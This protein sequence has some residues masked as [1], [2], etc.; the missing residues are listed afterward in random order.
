MQKAVEVPQIQYVGKI[1]EAL[2]VVAHQPV[3]VDA[4]ALSQTQCFE[5]DEDISVGT[6]S[7][8][9]ADGMSDAEHGLVQGRQSRLE[10]DET[11]ERSAAEGGKGL[12]LLQVAPNM[13]AAGSHLHATTG[14][15]RIVDWTQ[16]LREIRRIVEFLVRR[17][18]K[19]DVKADVAVRRLAR[20][21]KEHSQVEDEE[22]E[23]SFP[24][25][26]ADRTKVVN[27]SSTSGS[28]TQ[29]S[30][31]ATSPQAKSSSS[32]PALSECRSPHDRYL[33]VDA[34]AA[35]HFSIQG[36]VPSEQSLETRRAELAAKLDKEVSQV[37]SHLF[38]LARRAGHRHTRAHL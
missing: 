33:R 28:S 19:L 13:E 11:R 31:L 3:P 5:R 16:D 7:A 14:D 9:S 26:L 20:L 22:L 36:E 12:D 27:S 23:A 24:D 25:A 29:A 2:V 38:R 30:A 15:E 4:E 34:G 32:T 10:V 18:R 6:E 37:C 17:E 1:V 8:E 35:R 21:E